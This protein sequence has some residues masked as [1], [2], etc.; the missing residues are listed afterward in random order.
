[1][2]DDACPDDAA[3]TPAKVPRTNSGEQNCRLVLVA[4]FIDDTK[5]PARTVGRTY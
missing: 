5:M 2:G 4:L 3:P 1:M